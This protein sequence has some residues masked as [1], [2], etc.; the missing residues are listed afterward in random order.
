M[1]VFVFANTGGKHFIE[2]F[3]SA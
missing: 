1:T 3:T 2:V